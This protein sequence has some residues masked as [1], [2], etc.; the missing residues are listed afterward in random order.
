MEC[1]TLDF[2]CWDL[3]CDFVDYYDYYMTPSLDGYDQA[4][5]CLSILTG[6]LRPYLGS[7]FLC[8]LLWIDMPIPHI[9]CTWDISCTSCRFSS[10]RVFS[11]PCYCKE[12]HPSLSR[13]SCFRGHLLHSILSLSLLPLLPHIGGP[14]PGPVRS[15]ITWKHLH[16]IPLSMYF[17]CPEDTF[18]KIPINI[19]FFPLALFH[20]VSLALMGEILQRGRAS[21]RSVSESH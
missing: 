20:S 18:C 10:S 1:K 19:A 7:R 6:W 3:G 17:I 21:W 16:C 4:R 12:F 9:S 15:D 13:A 14:I 5:V 8:T 2:V 11:W